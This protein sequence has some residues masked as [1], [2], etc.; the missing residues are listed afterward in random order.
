VHHGAEGEPLRLDQRVALASADA[1][2]PSKPHTPPTPVVLTDWPSRILALGCGSRPTAT[3]AR[4]RR[5]DGTRSHVPSGRQ[6]RSQRETACRGGSSRGD[7]RHWRPA[8]TG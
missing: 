8:R 1:L 3:R 5:T 6:R 7:S 2:G 4:S